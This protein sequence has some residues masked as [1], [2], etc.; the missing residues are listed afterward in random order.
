MPDTAANQALWPQ[1]SS[2]K[3]GCG[4]PIMKVVGLFSLTTGALQ[5]LACGTLRNAEQALCI[6]LWPPLTQAFD[7]ML[8]DRHFGSFATFCAL[9][10]SGLHG[11]FRLHQGRKVDW[12]RGRRLG[13]FDRLMT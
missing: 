7:L 8:G 5:A 11:V 1:P 3:P 13:K 12:R 10:L 6:Q 2:Q 9:Q 4:F